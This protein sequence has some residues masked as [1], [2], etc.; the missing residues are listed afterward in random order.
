MK[1]KTEKFFFLTL[2]HPYLLQHYSQQ[3][4]YE[5]STDFPQL[6]NGLKNVVYIHNGE[7]FSHKEE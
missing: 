1:L 5:N 7:L 3:P 2:A 4:R 6:M